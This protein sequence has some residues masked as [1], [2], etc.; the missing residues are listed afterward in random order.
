MYNIKCFDAFKRAFRRMTGM[1]FYPFAVSIWFVLGFSAWLA[2]IF[3]SQGGSGAGGTFYFKFSNSGNLPYIIS[4]GGSFLKDVF[5][6]DVFFVGKICNYFKI[7]QSVF[8]WLVFG[9]AASVLIMIVINLI[10]VWVSSRFKFIFI[11]N[12][13]NNRAEIAK[14]WEQFKRCGNSAFWWLFGFILVSVLFMLII[15]ICA[16]A[17]LYPLIQDFLSTKT[18]QISDANSVFLVLTIAVFVT[19]V[20]ILFFT[21][22]FFNEFVLPI[23][24]KKDLRAKAAYREFLQLFKAAPLTFLKFWF[25]QILANIACG[26]A[27]ILLIITTCGIVIIPLLMPYFRAL[28]ILPV[29]V[30]HRSQS[31]ELMAAFGSEYSPYPAPI[32]SEKTNNENK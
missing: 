16:S 32:E 15:F 12:I 1:L 17:L 18:L 14:P 25:L 2:I 20:V 31:M 30:F 24:Y 28:V 13:A 9:T 4:R 19:G 7:E 23:M 8:W 29:L 26:I 21:Y 22:Y 11:D 3:N 5:L 10:L 27:V 6:G